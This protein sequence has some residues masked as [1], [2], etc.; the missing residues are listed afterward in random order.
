LPKSKRKENELIDTVVQPDVC[1]ICDPN[2]IDEAGCLGA[3]DWI[4]EILSPHTSAKDLRQKFDVYEQSGVGEYC[5]VHPA[6]ATVLVFIL[7]A[8][9]KYESRVKP[10]IR[11]D[12]IASITIP[13]LEIDL[14]EVFAG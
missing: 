9:G 8:E 3:P 10:Y 7:N 11:T 14:E 5:V 4:I 2:K 12:K 13:G 1:V 6:E